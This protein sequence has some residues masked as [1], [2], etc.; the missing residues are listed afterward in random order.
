MALAKLDLPEMRFRWAASH[1]FR[2]S[3]TGLAPRW[4]KANRS[5]GSCPRA[6]FA[7]LYKSAMRLIAS[8]EISKPEVVLLFRP[9]CSDRVDSVL[10]SFVWLQSFRCGRCRDLSFCDTTGM[11]ELS[12]TDLALAYNPSTTEIV[13]SVILIGAISSTARYVSGG[14]IPADID[15]PRTLRGQFSGKAA[16]IKV[17]SKV[18]APVSI[19]AVVGTGASYWKHGHAAPAPQSPSPGRGKLPPRRASFE[20]LVSQE[21]DITLLNSGM[22]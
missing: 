2:A 15:Y 6:A 8:A 4:R 11:S 10:H 1:T 21:P 3:K 5:S 14:V 16:P 12:R 13:W 7:N 18:A 17:V 22:H 20:E 19:A 9:V